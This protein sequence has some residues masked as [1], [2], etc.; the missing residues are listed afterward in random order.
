[1]KRPSIT[2]REIPDQSAAVLPELVE[3]PAPALPILAYGVSEA[4][5]QSPSQPSWWTRGLRMLGLDRAVVFTVLARGWSS[6]AGI[7]TLTLIAHF[8][9][10]VEQ[11][12]YYTFYSLVAMQIVFELG[13]STVILQAASHEAAHLEVAMNGPVSGPAA[14]HARLASVLQK[15]VRWYTAG[16]VLMVLVLLP[17]GIRF[18]HSSAAI[19]SPVA[20]LMPWCLVVIASGFTFQVDPMFSFLEG[21]GF[22]SNVARMRLAQAIVGTIL[23]WLALVLHHGLMA[24]GMMIGGQAAVGCVYIARRRGLLLPL[25]RHRL[26]GYAIDWKREIWPFQWRIAVSWI[27]GFFITQLFNPVLFKYRGAIEAGQMGMTISVCGTLTSMAIAWM[28]TKAAPFGRLIALRDFAGLD[29]MF[30]GALKQSMA[31]ALLASAGAWAAVYY[32]R[33]HGIAFALRL[34]PPGAFALLLLATIGNIAVFA[35]AL[36]L[37]A[38]KQEKFMLNSILGAVWMVPAT[39]LLG[40]W[41]GAFGIVAGYC[42]CTLAVG[43]G[44]G[45]ATFVKYRRLWHA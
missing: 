25:L 34:L 29:R 27:C 22:V 6:L 36:Y 2:I 1:M 19:N 16:A 41:Y 33:L 37:R 9:S 11:G 12:Y 45:T 5:P 44:L 4:A 30:F 20:W 35:E 18:F 39:L 15:S 3:L 28:N 13:F 17:V 21:C 10:R 42:A 24:P 8:L 40:R 23:G 43:V 32:L 7:G 31:A 14:N 26:G 38:H